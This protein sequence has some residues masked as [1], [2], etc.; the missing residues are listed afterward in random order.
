MGLNLQAFERQ[1]D[2]FRD[3]NLS[4]EGQL[5]L[6]REAAEDTKRRAIEEWTQAFGALPAFEQIVDGVKSA[7]IDEAERVVVLRVTPLGVV[8]QFA[9]NLLKKFS[10]VRTDPPGMING[11]PPGR[12]RNSFEIEVNGVRQEFVDLRELGANDQIVI[13]SLVPYARVL[14]AG[15]DNKAK[16]SGLPGTGGLLQSV[17]AA[18]KR[19]FGKTAAV[20]F[21][22]FPFPGEGPQGPASRRRTDTQKATD[23]R[24]PVIVISAFR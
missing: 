21:A 9:W 24:F 11:F 6:F 12:Y 2:V 4:R 15:G 13:T 23:D 3:E 19:E 18:T 17:A 20:G 14:E 5:R 22:W 7:P 16:G 1:I 10:K 8:A